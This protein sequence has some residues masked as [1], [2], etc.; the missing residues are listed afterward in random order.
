[1]GDIGDHRAV[2]ALAQLEPLELDRSQPKAHLAIPCH[3]V[4]LGQLGAPLAAGRPGATGAGALLRHP[5]RRDPAG[6]HPPPWPE[7]CRLRASGGSTEGGPH[8]AAHHRDRWEQ[9]LL[10]GRPEEA[11]EVAL[12]RLRVS[13]KAGG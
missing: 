11:M 8:Q 9:L 13:E 2:L 5:R 6:R 4:T 1:M 12:H 3:K 10:A 7:R